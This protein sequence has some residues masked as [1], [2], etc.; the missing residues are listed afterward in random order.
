MSPYRKFRMTPVMVGLVIAVIRFAGAA[1][2]AAAAS[3]PKDPC[4]LLKPAE[5]QA[6][7]PNAK[8]GTRVST[9]NTLP[10]VVSC[11]YGWG[12]RNNEWG[13]T[14]LGVAIT[15]VSKVWPGGL[16][17]DDIKQRVLVEA[18]SGGP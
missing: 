9:T 8:I 2:N 13:E 3:L 6:L 1:T 12:D 10:L 11:E 18:T 5:I 14:T 17:P 16:S 4:A 7:I 15:D